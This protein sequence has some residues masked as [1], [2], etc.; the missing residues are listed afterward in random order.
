MKRLF[1]AVSI[2]LIA[3]LAFIGARQAPTGTAGGGATGGGWTDDG[4]NMR[5]TTSTDNVGIGT[6]TPGA[7]LEV[8]GQVKI[9]GGAPALNKVLT[10]DADGLATWALPKEAGW[11]D[12]GNTVRL[13]NIN[14]KVG[15]GTSSP[16]A[17]LDVGGTPGAIVG[18]FAGGQLQVTGQS[19]SV[20]SNA[21][22]TGHNLFG[23]NKQLWYFGSTSSSNDNIA[24]INRQNAELHFNTNNASR[25]MIQADGD[26][27]IG[28]TSPDAKLEVLAAGLPQLRITHT[29]NVDHLDISVTSAGSGILQA[30]GGQINIGNATNDVT[31]IFDVLKILPRS[32]APSGA[33]GM[34][35][36]DSDL[37]LP[38]FYNGTNWVQMD[39]FSTVC[40]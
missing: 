4:T 36:V 33:L 25:M 11:T 3:G 13:T 27:G 30:S 20:N 22:I 5:L 35:Y 2:V 16:N 32:T 28:D 12:V 26:V 34:I 24:F 10:S 29:D 37:N 15:I 38:C 19:A 39:D 9:T 1:F 31:V 18:G 40:S 14:D 8:V 21:V 6:I 7:K 23:G 17:K